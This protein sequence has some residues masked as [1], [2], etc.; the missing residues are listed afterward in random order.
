MDQIFN[1]VGSYWFNQKASSQ[2]N[3]VGDDINSMTNSIEGG[4]KWLVNKIK[5]FVI[6]NLLY[7]NVGTDINVV[8]VVQYLCAIFAMEDK[9][10]IQAIALLS[11]LPYFYYFFHSIWNSRMFFIIS[12]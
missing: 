2:L 9:E 5:G 3:S 6:V 11:A 1:K 7:Y 12:F 8:S 4:T 10:L